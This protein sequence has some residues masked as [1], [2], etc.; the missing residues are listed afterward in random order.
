MDERF[1]VQ[2]IHND[3]PPSEAKLLITEDQRRDFMKALEYWSSEPDSTESAE[4]GTESYMKEFA[5]H[6]A[7]TKLVKNRSLRRNGVQYVRGGTTVVCK[8]ADDFVSL[9]VEKRVP[10]VDSEH[11]EVTSTEYVIDGPAQEVVAHTW[12]VDR[13]SGDPIENPQEDLDDDMMQNLF[14]FD[15]EHVADITLPEGT[16]PDNAFTRG[17][18]WETEDVLAQLA[19]EGW[20]RSVPTR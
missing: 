19:E 7:V 13:E 5:P 16:D 6:R 17:R 4:T 14:T 10:K 15:S 8:A 2:V 9:R 12:L 11:D 20:A 3:R 18:Y 1:G